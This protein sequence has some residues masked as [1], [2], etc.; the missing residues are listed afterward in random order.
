MLKTMRRTAFLFSFLASGHA[1]VRA[2]T[3]PDIDEVLKKVTATYHDVTQYELVRIIRSSGP[4]ESAETHVAFMSPDKYRVEVKTD[5]LPKGTSSALAAKDILDIFDG[6]TLWEYRPELRIYT[7]HNQL[8]RDWS[9]QDVDRNV[10]IGMFRNLADASKSSGGAQAR[11]LRET[12]FTL[13]GKTCSCVVIE[14]ASSEG[15]LT[16]WIDQDSWHV[17]RIHL[18]SQYASADILFPL[19]KLNEPQPDRLFQFKPPPGT[20]N[21]QGGVHH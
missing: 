4:V 16:F 18:G 9:A 7:K 13:N 21:S 19:I 12:Q 17:L 11:V 3:L 15:E 14:T 10:G 8:P 2:Q 5:K 6:V 20:S 1:P